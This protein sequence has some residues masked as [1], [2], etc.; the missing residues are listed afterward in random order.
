MGTCLGAALLAGV[1]ALAQ[2]GISMDDAIV[3]IQGGATRVV[4]SREGPP[5]VVSLSDLATGREFAAGDE[6]A[7]LLWLCVSPAGRPDGGQTWLSGRQARSTGCEVRAP[8][9]R[10]VGGLR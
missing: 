2:S 4:L 10:V 3:N 6:G 7:E 1:L 5:C 8:F 9:F